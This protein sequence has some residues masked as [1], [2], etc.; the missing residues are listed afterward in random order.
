MSRDSVGTCLSVIRSLGRSQVAVL[1]T[2][3][4]AGGRL[5]E[6]CWHCFRP[7][8]ERLS[9]PHAIRLASGV[10]MLC[11]AAQTLSPVTHTNQNVLHELAM[12]AK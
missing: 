8:G 7:A 4:P 6:A 1:F 2:G 12:V 3:A 5:D 11:R 9:T 10:A